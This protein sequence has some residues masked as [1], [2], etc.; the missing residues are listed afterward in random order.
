MQAPLVDNAAP[1]VC[2]LANVSFAF[3]PPH[4]VVAFS[5]VSFEVG[6]GESVALCGPSGSGKSTLLALLGMLDVPTSG[7]YLFGGLSVADLGPEKRNHLRARHVGFVFQAFHLIAG[8]NVIDNVAASLLYTERNRGLRERRARECIDLVGLGHRCWHHP[9]ELSG[10]ERQRVA[11]ARALAVGP[12]LILADEPTGNLDSAT[13]QAILQLLRDSSEAG[14]VIATH[15]DAV[16]QTLDRTV[17][18]C[19]GK[20]QSSG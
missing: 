17:T 8:R 20:I 10:G 11:I 13:G 9:N 5:D 7:E 18:M 1:F 16:A 3:P 14:L 15:D 19:D 4:R 6:Q 2:K 12:S